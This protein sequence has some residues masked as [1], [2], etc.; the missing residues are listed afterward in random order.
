MGLDDF[1]RVIYGLIAVGFVQD[2]Y[3]FHGLMEAQGFTASAHLKV[4]LMASQAFSR[5]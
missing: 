5:R 1:E 2:A 4:A 3:R